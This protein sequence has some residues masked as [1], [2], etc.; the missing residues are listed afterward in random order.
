[1]EEQVIRSFFQS[2]LQDSTIHRLHY[3]QDQLILGGVAILF[4]CFFFLFLN[5]SPAMTLA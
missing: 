5:I 4:V 3:F 2:L 1:M